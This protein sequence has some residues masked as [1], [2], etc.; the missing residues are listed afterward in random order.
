[1]ARHQ[2]G[3]FAEGTRAH[4]HLEFSLR[5]GADD[6]QVAAALVGVR[7]ANA[8]HRTTGGV[9]L[10]IGLGPALWAR[11]GGDGS[12]AV[13][14]DFPGYGTEAIG[15]V[16]PA[17]QRDVWIWTHGSSTDVVFDVVRAVAAALEPVA[18][19]QL[20]VTGFTYHDS[21]DLT[22]FIDG[23]ANPFLDEAPVV[24]VIPEGEPG[25]G[26][27]CAMTIR[28][29]HDLRAFG[30]L[31]EH[32]QE[33]VFGRTKADSVEMAPDVKPPDSHIGLAEVADEDGEEL[34][35]YRRSVPWAD[36][37]EQGLQFVS[38]GRDVDRFDLQLRHIYGE[39]DPSLVDRLLTFTTALTGSF[40]FCPS[41]EDLDAIAPVADDD[42]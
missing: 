19:L 40:W 39:V 16:A 37:A 42:E 21:R 1:M 26:G 18:D 17:T 7:A 4:H 33:L 20:D 28:F 30:E 13:V 35:V 12:A 3:I 31:A 29:R 41:V 9:N 6:A 38:F 5:P 11:L 24:A 23:T 10:V 14:R 27:S 15:H 25:E 32:D 34:D 2:Y 36:A 22:G 8:D